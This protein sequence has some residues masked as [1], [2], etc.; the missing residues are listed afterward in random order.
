[1]RVSQPLGLSL[2][3]R[4]WLTSAR[5]ASFIALIGIV[6]MAEC[7]RRFSS[8]FV[9]AWIIRGLFSRMY[10]LLYPM[11]KRRVFH[12]ALYS[13]AKVG[14]STPIYVLLFVTDL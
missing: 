11:P 9:G 7:S 1:M 5:E 4:L 13:A 10:L 2:I 3:R 12:Y 6:R 8:T 14:T